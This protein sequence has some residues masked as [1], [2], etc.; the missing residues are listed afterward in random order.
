MSY[1]TRLL[2]IL[3]SSSIEQEVRQQIE[4]L[5]ENQREALVQ[6]VLKLLGRKSI[7]QPC[8]TSR[9]R[10]PSSSENSPGS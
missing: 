7:R 6:V 4:Q 8:S 1:A 5:W 3:T 9:R 2:L 10:S